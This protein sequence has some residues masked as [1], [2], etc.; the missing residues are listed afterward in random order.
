M[1]AKTPDT[2]EAPE[3]AEAAAPPALRYLVTY[4]KVSIIHG[5]DLVEVIVPKGDYLD[6]HVPADVA[7]VKGPELLTFGMAVTVAGRP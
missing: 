3:V 1:P 7:A 2:P 6:Q 4:P 5:P